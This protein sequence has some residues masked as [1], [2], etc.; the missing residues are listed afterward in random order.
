MET[1]TPEERSYYAR[2]LVIPRF[3]EETQIRLKGAK[4][5]VVGAG[6]LGCPVLQYLNAAGVGTL[7]IADGDQVSLHNLH[8]QVLYRT[9]DVGKEKVMVAERRL[10]E[11]NPFSNIITYAANVTAA[12]GSSFLEPFQLVLDCSDN[13]ATRYLLNDRCVRANKPFVS[14]SVFRW[15]GQMLVCNYRESATYRCVFPEPPAPEDSPDC[16]STGVLGILPGII[17]SL[18]AAE[19]LKILT[20]QGEVM[21][22]RLL[23]YDFNLQEFTWLQLERN[24]AAVD[25]MLREAPWSDGQYQYFCGAPEAE[26]NRVKGILAAE[27]KAMLRRQENLQLIDVREPEEHALMHIGGLL[28][29]VAE[30]ME[31]AEEISREQP[32]VFYCKTGFRSEL[33]IRRL[34]DKFGWTNLYN[35]EGG[36]RAYYAQQV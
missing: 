30:V 33:V 28:M 19:A 24:Q 35:L 2:Q 6:G 34:Q 3:G 18:M 10:R 23:N 36:I 12:N 20:G 22:N 8:R 17:G 15:S 32:V 16:E 26:E 13:F 29:P 21:R 5:L 31:R 25:A 11:Q 7:G 4:V 14:G 27:L 9:E 1:L